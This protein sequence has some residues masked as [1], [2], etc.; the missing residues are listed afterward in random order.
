LLRGSGEHPLNPTGKRSIPLS[1]DD[2]EPPADGAGQP[3]L[4]AGNGIRGRADPDMA[5]PPG[6]EHEH[7]RIAEREF[8]AGDYDEE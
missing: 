2:L 6:A 1:A 7:L 4:R 3:L 5:G 8:E